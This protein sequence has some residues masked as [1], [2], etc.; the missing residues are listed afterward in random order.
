[1]WNGKLK[2]VT[3]SYDDG[4]TQDIRF[5]EMLDRYGLK[6][7]FNLNSELLG[8]EGHLIRQEQWVNH[9]K[10]K[11]DEVKKIYKDHEVAVHTLTHP[12]LKNIEDD[13]EVIRQ[14]EQDRLNLEKLVGYPVHG[15]AY[16]CGGDCYDERTVRLL[17]ENTGVKFSR[18][19]YANGSFDLWDE[20]LTFH[21]TV[22]HMNFDKMFEL[23][24]KFIELKPDTPKLYYIWGHTYE[25]DIHNTWDKMEEFL[26]LI[27]GKDDIFYGTNSE[28]LL[29]K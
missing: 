6:A 24:E 11:P 27:S 26:K 29:K 7:T 18:T 5:I 28:I 23:G 2:A 17:R 25:F 19:T 16:P 1:M 8:L 20:L 21:P 13:G 15:M 9:T 14:V 4:V 3:F 12:N 10:V 22:Y